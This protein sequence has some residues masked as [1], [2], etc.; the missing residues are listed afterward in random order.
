LVEAAKAVDADPWRD[1]VRAT[2]G[3][4]DA[5]TSETLRKLADNE[6]GLEAQPATS[7]L[8]LSSQLDGMGDR[9]RAESVLRLAWRL[10]PDDFFVNFILG[11]SLHTGAPDKEM[12]ARREEASR[13]LTA[14]VAIRPGSAM[15]HVQLG[16]PC[17][18][19]GKA[20]RRSLNT[21][22]HRT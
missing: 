4:R 22:R 10:K 3:K 12:P 18:R 8:L 1:A 5:T 16:T 14:A 17:T 2:I 9:A 20:M 6:K 21:A 7:L 11:Q 15:A 19:W 13:H